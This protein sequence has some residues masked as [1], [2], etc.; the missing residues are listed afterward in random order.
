MEKKK[1]QP[2]SKMRSS[3]ACSRCRRSKIKCVNAGI[4]TTCRACESSGRECVYPTPAAGSAAAANAAANGLAATNGTSTGHGHANGATKRDIT[5]ALGGVDGEHERNGESDGPK[6]QRAKKSSNSNSAASG[7]DATSRQNGFM[8]ALDSPMLT[9]KLWNELFEHFQKH[10]AATLPF[11]QRTD[12]LTQTR[13]HSNASGGL[14]PDGGSENSRGSSSR[15]DASLVLLGVLTL[16]ARF[17]PQL[18]QHHSPSSSASPSNPL[19]ASEFYSN[20]LRARLAGADGGDLASAD[21]PRIQ[22]YLMLG[23]HE[24]GMC[25]GKTAWIY[26]GMAIRMSQTLGLSIDSDSD[27]TSSS[28]RPSLHSPGLE[29]HSNKDTKDFS[30]EDVMEQEAKRRT[31]WSCFMLDRL[32]SG[33]RH[34]PRAIRVRD[35]SIQLPS[36]SAF[37]FGERVRTSKLSSSSSASHNRRSQS[38]ET[39]GVQI[40]SLRQSIGYP[41]DAKLRNG[42][43]TDSKQWPISSHRSDDADEKIDRWEVGTDECFLGRLI[44]IIKIWGGIA[45]WSCSGG[46]K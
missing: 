9:Q 8:A 6:R 26:V 10:F 14:G 3:I 7:R 42:S 44:R 35:I 34:R 23:L 2:T 22:A 40:P 37:D 12:F 45:K 38:H 5:A 39:R 4:D 11:L 32:L 1:S 46:R 24:W 31:F 43:V 21:I 29:Q 18:I 33:G 27:H 17:S 20:A 30:S 13:Q 36:D 19:A 41:D 28:R 15:T 16:T 25:R